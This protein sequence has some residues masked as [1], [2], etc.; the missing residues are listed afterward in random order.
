M[1]KNITSTFQILLLNLLFVIG[2]TAQIT[3][4]E[5]NVLHFR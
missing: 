1:K 2:A 3:C 4:D 5:P